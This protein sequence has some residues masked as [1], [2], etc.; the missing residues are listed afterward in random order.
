MTFFIRW[1]GQSSSWLVNT[2]KDKLL[3]VLDKIGECIGLI[4]SG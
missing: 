1:F 4:N 3:S 2:M